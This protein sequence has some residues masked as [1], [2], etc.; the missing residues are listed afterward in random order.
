MS[1][2]HD[3]VTDTSTGNTKDVITNKSLNMDNRKTKYALDVL[4]IYRWYTSQVTQMV[5]NKRIY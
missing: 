1:D 5:N 2:A 4:S 3:Y